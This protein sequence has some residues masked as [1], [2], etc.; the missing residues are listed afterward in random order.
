MAEVFFADG[1]WALVDSGQHA[2][3]LFE[4]WSSISHKCGWF[5]KSHA[6]RPFVTYKQSHPLCT[7]CND[8]VPPELVGLWKI[9][10]WDQIQELEGQDNMY[11]HHHGFYLHGTTKMRPLV[12]TN[13]V[14]GMQGR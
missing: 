4:G 12:S 14:Y 7:K 1:K 2:A 5:G 13:N 9:H 10:N 11:K 6:T 8:E 3:S